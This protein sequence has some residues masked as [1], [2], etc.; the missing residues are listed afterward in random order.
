M[1]LMNELFGKL[2]KAQLPWERTGMASLTRS[3]MPAV[4]R[5]LNRCPLRRTPMEM[6]FPM[7]GNSNAASI[8]TTPPMAQPPRAIAS[9][10]IWR[11]IWSFVLKG[12][13][14]VRGTRDEVRGYEVR[15]PAVRRSTKYESEFI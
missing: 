3:L 14:E 11:L 5:H 10:R 6:A 15:L 2:W 7:S 9:I 1:P 8:P 12:Y 13:N 4:G